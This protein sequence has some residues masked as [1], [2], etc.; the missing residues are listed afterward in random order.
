MK[1]QQGVGIVEVLVALVVVSLGV[2]GMASLQLTGMHCCAQS[3]V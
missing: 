3:N 2:L 1:R